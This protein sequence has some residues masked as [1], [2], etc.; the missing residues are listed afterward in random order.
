MTHSNM[1]LNGVSK[2]WAITFN[3]LPYLKKVFNN[4]KS[5]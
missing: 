5:K 1:Y 4:H 3:H 2:G